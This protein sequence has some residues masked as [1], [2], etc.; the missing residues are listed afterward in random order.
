MN[1]RTYILENKPKGAEVTPEMV[2]LLVHKN[3]TGYIPFANIQTSNFTAVNLVAYS[4]NGTLTVTDPTPETNKGY[5]VHV[6]GGTTTIDGVAYT[7]GALVYRFYNGTVWSSKDYGAGGGTYTDEQ[8]QDAVGGILADTSEIDFTYSDGTPSITA[9]LRNN[10]I[11]NARLEHIAANHVKGRLSGNGVVQ[12]IAM[13]DLPVSTATQTALDL[14]ANT[15]SLPLTIANGVPSATVTASVLTLIESQPI[16]TLAGKNIL[17]ILKLFHKVGAV[18]ETINAELRLYDTVLMTE[19][20]I[21]FASSNTNSGHTAIGR[22]IAID[23][24]GGFLRVIDV[25]VGS[26]ADD[27]MIAN[28]N[29]TNIP[30]PNVNNPLTLRTYLRNGWTGSGMRQYSS[31]IQVF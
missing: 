5:I 14:K 8:A 23:I 28:Q 29:V 30:I 2:K 9:S 4:T 7:A 15:S 16:G 24:A 27:I 22:H 18:N 25:N 6:V 19:T 3:E 1:K 12:D 26:N 21:G 17:R 31:L 13:T 20:T 11:A 10:S